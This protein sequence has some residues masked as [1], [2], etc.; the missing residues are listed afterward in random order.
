GIKTDSGEKKFYDKVIV[1]VGRSGNAWMQE[2]ASRYKIESD[3]NPVD[4]GVRVEIP[5]SVSDAFTEIL[6]EF[7][8]KYH[9]NEFE[10]EVRTFCVNPGGYVAQEI[11][12]NNLITV[13]GHSYK[14]RKSENT[15]FA[16]LV[17]TKFTEP[18]KEP[19]KYGQYIAYL[20]NMLSGGNI[21]VQRFG[22]LLRGRRSTE[23]RIRK[24]FVIPT[25]K[26]AMPGDLS[27]VLPYRYLTNIKETIF[28]LDKV[29]PGVADPNTLLY[30][31]EVKFYSLRIKVDNNLKSISLANLYC[32]GDGA[33][34]TRGIIQASAS[35]L[36][37]A[38][39]IISELK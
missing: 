22:D 11:N 17:S 14:N 18:F 32:I 16:L 1:A 5:K 30:G 21:I 15:N 7:K 13:N 37:A 26:T 12:Q 24:N 19:V 35:G 29:M 4:I 23:S 28:Q 27:F 33:G 3:I 2:M 25:L 10:D 20:A 34:V 31:V 39:S 38:N 36:I 6:Y 8:I 9:T